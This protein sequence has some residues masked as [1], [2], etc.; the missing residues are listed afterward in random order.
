M[1]PDRRQHLPRRA[2]GRPAV[3]HAS[4]A[5]VRR[6]PDADRRPV[7]ML[8]RHARGR[9]RV[10]HPRVQ[11]RA[12]DPQGSEAPRGSVDEG[13]VL[14][15]VLHGVVVPAFAVLAAD[16][17]G[18]LH[19]LGP[20]Q[21]HAD[22][23]PVRR[24]RSGVLAPGRARRA[25]GR[26]RRAPGRDHRPRRREVHAAPHVP[27]PLAVRRAAVQVRADHRAERRDRERSD[28]AASRR[29]PLL[30]LARR[31]RRDAV[32]ARRAGVRRDGRDD[33]RTRRLAAPGPGTQE[34]GRDPSAVR[35][36]GRG[37]AL[38]PVLGGGARVR[39]RSSSR[40]RGGRARSGTRSTCATDRAAPSC[41][42][43]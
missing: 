28:P 24:R 26:R 13:A 27:G 2:V 40:G 42:T 10:R 9:G 36:R 20:V 23:D 25:V 11:L 32:R 19:E 5:R 15:H 17:R 12:R 6:L 30:A 35:G 8:E 1:E 4:R 41:G 33:P 31:L 39:S 3:P 43:A 14:V 38:L 18:R 7:S 21:P 29:E 34:Q 22:P 37:S 16:G